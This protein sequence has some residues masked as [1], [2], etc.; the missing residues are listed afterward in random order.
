MNLTADWAIWGR[1]LLV[2]VV[3]TSLVVCA[4]AALSHFIRSASWLRLVWRSALVGWVL[5]AALEFTGIGGWISAQVADVS[6][7]AQPK[8]TAVGFVVQTDLEPKLRTAVPE[9]IREDRALLT[10]D[11]VDQEPLLDRTGLGLFLAWVAGSAVFFGLVLWRR[12][13]VL[14]SGFQFKRIVD[15]NLAQRFQSLRKSFGAE[16]GH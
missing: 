3:E 1:W 7:A 14:V 9:S 10:E 8:A 6:L 12:L 15:E 5:L 16:E 13:A 11:Q 2:L 4:A